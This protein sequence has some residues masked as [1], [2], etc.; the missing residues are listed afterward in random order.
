MSGLPEWCLRERTRVAVLIIL[1]LWSVG[2]VGWMLGCR[3][4]MHVRQAGFDHEEH[5]AEIAARREQ[6]AE[7]IERSRAERA[8]RTRP[9]LSAQ[10]VAEALAVFD[11]PTEVFEPVPPPSDHA[12][13]SDPRAEPVAE[14]TVEPD[15][16]LNAEPDTGGDSAVE[17]AAALGVE[18][19]RWPSALDCE[20]VAQAADQA[21]Q[22]AESGKHRLPT[23]S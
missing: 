11:A 23:P 19:A 22:D 17:A 21:D 3:Y 20:T 18:L 4:L 6:Q 1:L 5:M 9:D 14:P 7:D 10:A 13:E 15:A 2:G 8:S 12:P 16:E